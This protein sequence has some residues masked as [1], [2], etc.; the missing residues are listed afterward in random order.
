M[1]LRTQLKNKRMQKGETKQLE[2]I[3][4]TIEEDELIMTTL[5]GLTRPLDAFIQT[6]CAR[7]EKLKFDSLWEECIQEETRV[8]NYEALLE[9][10]DDKALYTHTK[11]GRKKPYFQKETHKEPQ[12]PNKFNNKESHSRRFQK[13]GQQK[14]RDYSSV[15]CHHCDTMGHIMK[16]YLARREEYKRK[17]KRH[18]AHVV[19]DEEPPA[20]MIRE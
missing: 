8:S 2:M 11:R 10:D 12:P 6:T 5:N 7:T 9:R 20:K 16:L 13:K 17:H 18:H 3:G 19:K 4:D 14:E 15:Q 1:N